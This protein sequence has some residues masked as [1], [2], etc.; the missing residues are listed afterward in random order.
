[1]YLKSIRLKNIRCFD[2]VEI[3]FDLD[4]GNNRKWTVLLGENGTVLCERTQF[5]D[6]F[7]VEFV[8]VK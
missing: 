7:K 4:G 6:N 3:N 2:D 5:E 1:M 8:L